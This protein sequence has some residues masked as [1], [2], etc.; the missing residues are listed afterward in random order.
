MYSLKLIYKDIV[1]EKKIMTEIPT[2]Y[3]LQDVIETFFGKIRSRCG[4]NN[5]PNVD[6]FKGAYRMLLANLEII[7]SNKSNCRI[8]EAL[9]SDL[10]DTP[11][12]SN[13]YFISS[14]RATIRFDDIKEKYNEQK[15]EI[16]MEIERL[17]DLEENNLLLHLTSNFNIAYIATLIEKKIL[18]SP[19]F[20]CNKCQQVFEENE[21]YEAI[22]LNI[23]K[24]YPC[25]STYKI[26][27]N[28]DTFFKLY[29]DVI[30]N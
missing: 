7:S 26:F 24:S 9:D 19:R 29:E 13:V 30:N 17:N 12:Y 3:L 18:K 4:F 2:Y 10:P 20:Y 23:L 22:D 15:D 8:V 28:A 21:K 27:E 25:V 14:K 5:N 11:F 16:L 1:Q 6:Q